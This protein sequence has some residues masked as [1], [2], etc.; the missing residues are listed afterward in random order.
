MYLTC[1]NVN[2]TV[3]HVIYNSRIQPALFKNASSSP[4]M[5]FFCFSTQADAC[6]H[7]CGGFYQSR[8]PRCFVLFYFFLTPKFVIRIYTV[9]TQQKKQHDNPFSDDRLMHVCKRDVS[10]MSGS[11]YVRCLKPLMKCTKA[12]SNR[13]QG[14]LFHTLGLLW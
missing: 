10:G 4:D 11:G 8:D 14:N 13:T 1:S 9:A 5:F 12:P 2:Q 3:I 6:L 7:E